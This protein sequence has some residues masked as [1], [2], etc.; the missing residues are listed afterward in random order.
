MRAAVTGATSHL[1]STVVAAERGKSEPLKRPELPEHPHVAALVGDSLRPS[2][3]EEFIG[4]EPLKHRLSIIAMAARS[5]GEALP[6]ILL[7]G[8]PGLGKTTMANILANM[9]GVS[10]SQTAGMALGSTRDF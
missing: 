6:H 3:F 4:Q 9:M 8:P 5:R 2:R 10:F 1:P 7:A